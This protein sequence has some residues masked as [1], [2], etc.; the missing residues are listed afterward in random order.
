[1]QLDPAQVKALNAQIRH[2]AGLLPGK[3]DPDYKYGFSCE[4]GCGK[5]VPL[6]LREFDREG[7]W[8]D[9]HGPAQRRAS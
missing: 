7:A 9:A 1:V 4:C 5:I 2:M 6:S 3:D 8:A